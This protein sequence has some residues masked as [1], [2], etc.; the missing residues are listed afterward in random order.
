MRGLRKPQRLSKYEGMMLLKVLFTPH[1][2]HFTIG[3][4]TEL[5]KYVDLTLLSD[6]RYNIKVRQ[7]VTPDLPPMLRVFLKRSLWAV[8]PLLFDLFHVNRSFD[9]VSVAKHEGLIVT[10]HTWPDPSLVHESQREYYRRERDALLRLYEQGI[11]IITISNYCSKM[12]REKF[13]IRTS[14]VIYH[15]LL[16]MFR[17]REPKELA[18][19]QVIL[20]NSRLVPMKEPHLF[21][22]GLANINSRI[23]FKAVFRADGPLYERLIK[24]VKKYKL[25]GKVTFVEPMPF[26]KLHG[27][28][29]SATLLVHTAS[30]EPFGFA[31]LE[32][33]GSSLPVIVPREGGAHEVAGAG[34]LTFEPHDPV[35]L[36]EKIVS[37]VS[38]ADAY[39]KQSKRSLQRA[40]D[41]TW[42]KAAE[43]YLKV[44]QKLS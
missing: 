23:D 12:L 16:G 2:D 39:R 31:V 17:T 14:K 3:L 35:D 4:C 22:E 43:E 27:L 33:M 38:N 13:G 30:N 7:I 36:A 9:S 25:M 40:Q 19:K 32:A 10:E 26:E 44:Y 37:V 8:Y 1:V 6:K 24:L 20:W 21:V 15:G 29:K 5:A 41:F 28:Y 42:E 18:Q 34:A 11:P